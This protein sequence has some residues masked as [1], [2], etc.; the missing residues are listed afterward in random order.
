[1][2]SG[3]NSHNLIVENKLILIA[4]MLCYIVDVIDPVYKILL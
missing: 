4:I 2:F 1:M 3:Y